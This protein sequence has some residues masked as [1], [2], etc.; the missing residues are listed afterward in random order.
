MELFISGDR[1]NK[2]ADLTRLLAASANKTARLL[3]HKFRSAEAS[4]K[5]RCKGNPKY[6][7]AVFSPIISPNLE[8]YLAG[9]TS[10]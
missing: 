5:L 10:R 9:G 4:E 8:V 1:R 7:L 2:T 6:A 3:I